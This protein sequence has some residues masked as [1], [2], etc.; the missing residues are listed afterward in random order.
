M[1]EKVVE[2]GP[3]TRRILER[4]AGVQEG[5][6]S[7]PDKSVQ[8]VETTEP[9]AWLHAAIERL[10]A[11]IDEIFNTLT[12]EHGIPFEKEFYSVDEV[13][14]RS[15]QDG[16]TKYEAYTIRQACNK[17]RIPDAQKARRGQRWLIPHSALL[18]ILS[19]GLE[20]IAS[21]R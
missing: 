19:Q 8:I 17:G 2:L 16:V 5:T 7:T 9:S 20:P 1:S 6:L 21:K 3:I 4:I 18:R 15:K 10:E 11:R 12:Q 14:D 13:A